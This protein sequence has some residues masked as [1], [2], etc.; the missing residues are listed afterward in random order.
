MHLFWNCIESIVQ[1][2]ENFCFNSDN[3]YL[4]PE[5]TRILPHTNNLDHYCTN[6]NMLSMLSILVFFFEPHKLTLSFGYVKSLF[7]FTLMIIIFLA[8]QYFLQFDHLL[9]NYFLSFW[10]TSFRSSLEV[11][12]DKAVFW[13]YS[14]LER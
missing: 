9:W 4:S 14:L 5:Y 7:R 10:S 6:L 13:L 12:D 11:F 3:F 2:V 8:Y 1:F